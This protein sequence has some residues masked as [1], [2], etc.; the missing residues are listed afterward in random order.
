MLWLLIEAIKQGRVNPAL[1]FY[2][3]CDD[4]LRGLV[5]KLH[6]AE[7]YGFHMVAEGYEGFSAQDF[8]RILIEITDKGQTR[9]VVL[10]LDTAKKFVDL[11]DKRVSTEFGK[12]I[13]RFVLRGGTV[14]LLAHTNKKPRPDGRPE[15][16]GT[17]DLLQDVDAG[18]TGRVI[19][20]PGAAE[21]VVEF[22]NIKR[23]GDIAQRAIY[24]YSNADGLSYEQLLASVRRVADAEVTE[25]NVTAETRADAEAVD[26]V[27]DLI[28]SGTNTRE[29]LTVGVMTRVRWSRSAVRDLLDRYCGDNPEQHRWMFD[30]RARGAKV[31]RLH[32]IAEPRPESEPNT[33]PAG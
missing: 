24:A 11:M 20:E 13:R 9:G 19:S 33:E 10:I 31:Y 32:D 15:Y 12:V 17:G 2:I 7:T 26:V 1:V 18:Y 14:V 16:G 6:L 28:R 27:C 5:E 29:A 25:L 8:V 23:R 30:V 4:N 22:E 3:N 21:K